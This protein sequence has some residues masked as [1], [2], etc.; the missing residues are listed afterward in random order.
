MIIL[1]LS[2]V[3]WISGFGTK[4]HG[5]SPAATFAVFFIYNLS[6]AVNALLFLLTRADL[7][8]LGAAP[9]PK[10]DFPISSGPTLSGTVSKQSMGER[11]EAVV[12]GLSTEAR[13]KNHPPRGVLPEP[14]DGG[15]Q[16]EV[17]GN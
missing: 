17:D 5:V 4:N 9:K 1:P 10:L 12:A 7:L 3:R 6:G 2:V 11:G 8:L 15:W 14:G 13:V 16:P